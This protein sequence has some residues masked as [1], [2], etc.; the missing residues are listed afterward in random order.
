MIFKNK[1]DYLIKLT[2]IS[3]IFVFIGCNSKNNKYIP[4]ISYN[5]IETTNEVRLELP[6][7]ESK[8]IYKIDEPIFES[9]RKCSYTSKQPLSGV[10]FLNGD[11][12]FRL[13]NTSFA[14]LSVGIYNLFYIYKKN[15]EIIV[16]RESISKWVSDV[17]DFEIVF[18]GNLQKIKGDEIIKV[19]N[20]SP[21]LSKEIITEFISDY[22]PNINV[23]LIIKAKEFTLNV[24]QNDSLTESRKG[25]YFNNNLYT[26]SENTFDYYFN[27]D[28]LCYG[29]DTCFSK[30][31]E[32][33]NGVETIFFRGEKLS[34]S[35]KIIKINWGMENTTNLTKDYGNK[36][37]YSSEKIKV[38][39]GKVWVLLYINEHY[40]YNDGAN[41]T[42]VPILFVDNKSIDWTYGR[43]LSNVENIL[44]SKSKIENLIFHSNQSIIAI[45]DFQNDD[46][47]QYYGEMWF[48]ET[49][50]NSD[51]QQKRNE[52][53]LKELKEQNRI[54][55][56]NIYKTNS[57]IQAKKRRD[58]A[59]RRRGLSF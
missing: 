58:E 34:S 16:F 15:D 46:E 1:I 11:S 48:L 20:N 30:T 44:L 28:N 7:G 54:L 12:S 47:V 55:Q 4:S 40:N 43:N 6:N 13:V 31:K 25:I 56:E 36:L 33:I 14:K 22:D 32:T 9:G 21:N 27:G 45:S 51:L 49:T 52:F 37:R 29:E 38:P 24:F 42:S 35:E 2:S 3:L 41:I 17:V 10:S 8:I 50:M 59:D 23:E 18:K 5:E 53:D 19:K 26:N 39:N 57:A